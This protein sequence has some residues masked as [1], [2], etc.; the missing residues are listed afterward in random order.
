MIGDRDRLLD[1][2]RRASELELLT[3][4]IEHSS[5]IVDG[6]AAL[7][8]AIARRLDRIEAAERGEWLMEQA[9]PDTTALLGRFREHIQT[10]GH[11]AQADLARQARVPSSTLSK[12]AR[13]GHMSAHQRAQ[14]EAALDA[15]GREGRHG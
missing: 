5:G 8:A 2:S 1:L 11:G 15:V 12:F 9:M 6:F 10:A 3:R 14:L 13:T 7:Q 4:Q